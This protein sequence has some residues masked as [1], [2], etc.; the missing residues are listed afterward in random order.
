MLGLFKKSV[1]EM[2]F[3]LKTSLISIFVS[4]ASPQPE[5]QFKA[6]QVYQQSP[7]PTTAE[8]S[9]LPL[10]SHATTAKIPSRGERAGKEI[11]LAVLSICIVT[12]KSEE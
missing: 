7:S 11:F 1:L 2:H 9:S 10:S 4:S 12:Y 3:L 8:R 6:E 5:L